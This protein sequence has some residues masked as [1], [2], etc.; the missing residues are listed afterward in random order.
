M[1]VLENGDERQKVIN[2]MVAILHE[3]APWIWGY[4]PKQFSLYHAWNRNV[5]PN[6]MANNSLKYRSVEV[7]HREKSQRQWNK[8]LLWPVIAIFAVMLAFL[9]PAFLM[10]Q[11]KKKLIIKFDE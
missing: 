2:Q 9:I 4:H 5:K 6:L 7:K 11:K 8:P 10:Y 3:D 1:R